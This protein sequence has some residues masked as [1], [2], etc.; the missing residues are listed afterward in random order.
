MIL[1]TLMY[2]YLWLSRLI[3]AF[4]GRNLVA[5]IQALTQC[6]V[7]GTLIEHHYIKQNRAIYTMAGYG[8]ECGE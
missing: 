1:E 4:V 2:D 6:D 5:V 3:L 8:G 7:G